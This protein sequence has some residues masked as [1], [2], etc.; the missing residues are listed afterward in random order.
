MFA[1]PHADKA[2]SLGQGCI[3]GPLG[4]GH[5]QWLGRGFANR[6]GVEQPEV[7]RFRLG[8]LAVGRG[9][10]PNANSWTRPEHGR[11]GFRIELTVGGWS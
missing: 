7:R 11:T 2:Q 5:E 1:F 6:D 3:V 10:G 4:P 9:H 8:F